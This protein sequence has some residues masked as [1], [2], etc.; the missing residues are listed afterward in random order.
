VFVTTV[1]R[2]LRKNVNCAQMKTLTSVIT[3][4]PWTLSLPALLIILL[5]KI[6]IK[7]VGNAVSSVCTLGFLH[8][9]RNT[10]LI[11]TSEVLGLQIG[12]SWK[13]VTTVVETFF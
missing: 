11:T 7:T 1:G 12:M 6:E 3:S 5:G 9:K 2:A 4:I 8:L 10:C 13:C